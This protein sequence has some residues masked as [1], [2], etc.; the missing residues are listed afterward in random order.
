ARQ[1]RGTDDTMPCMKRILLAAIALATATACAA[2]AAPPPAPA[3]TFQPPPDSAIPSGP[4]GDVV[5]QG[6]AIFRDPAKYAAAFVGNQLRCSNCHFNAGRQANV[7]PL[8]AAYV[9]FPKY[10]AKNGHVN[11]FQ[12]RLQGCFAFSMNG[13]PPPL[14]DPV[15][16]AL[17]TYSYFLAKGLPTGEDAPGGGYPK[18]PAPPLP[19]DYARGGQVFTQHCALCHGAEGLGVSA[20][21]QVVFPALWGPRSFNWGAGMAE[22]NNAADF[23]HAN[24]PLGAGGTLTVQQA[25]DV[26]SYIDSQVRPQD[27]RFVSSAEETRRRFH[28]TP[29]SMYG[30]KVNGMVLGDPA[31]TPPFGT[32]PGAT[33]TR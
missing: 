10:R 22:I 2:G 7:A 29:F 15:L 30:L 17:E 4:F 32:V 9:S 31:T 5:R 8:W 33:G 28:D 3:A 24:M 26:A 12:E 11:S 16:V 14:G 1:C 19:A 18:L 20:G 13:K 27:P 6:E 25:W 23:I 21:G